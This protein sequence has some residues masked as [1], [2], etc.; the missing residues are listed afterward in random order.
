MNMVWFQIKRVTEES[1]FVKADTY[2]EAVKQAS[3][4]DEPDA[5]VVDDQFEEIVQLSDS[6]AETMEL[7]T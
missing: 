7:D 1:M 5:W 4:R 6:D 3:D 2:D